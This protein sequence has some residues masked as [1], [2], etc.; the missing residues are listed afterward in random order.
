MLKTI[1]KF[2]WAVV[3]SFDQPCMRIPL[4]VGGA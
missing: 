1:H 4:F 3:E 2:I